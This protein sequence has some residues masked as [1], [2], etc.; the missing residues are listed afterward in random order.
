MLSD[1]TRR[2]FGK[3]RIA[4]LRG[5]P[6]AGDICVFNPLYAR[7]YSVQAHQNQYNDYRFTFLMKRTCIHVPICLVLTLR[8]L[9]ADVS[10]C[11]LFHLK[12]PQTVRLS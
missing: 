5:V 7:P 12:L 1:G 4:Q 8:A 6:P 11:N 10:V 2:C 3:K 9:S